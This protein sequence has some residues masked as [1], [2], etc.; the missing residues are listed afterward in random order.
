[1]V[2]N[3]WA[4]HISPYKVRNLFLAVAPLIFKVSASQLNSGESNFRQTFLLCQNF[5]LANIFGVKFH[6]NLE[7]CEILK[8]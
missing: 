3:T 4:M 6:E 1:M 7:K 2:K 5:D 8:C